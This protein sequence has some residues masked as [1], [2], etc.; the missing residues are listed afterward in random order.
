[1][2]NQDLTVVENVDGTALQPYRNRNE[3]RELAERLLSLHPAAAD[4]GQAGMFAVAQLALMIGASPLPGTN[5]IHVWAKEKGGQKVIQFQLGINYYRRKAQE[6]GGVLWAVQPRQMNDPERKDYGIPAGQLAAIC[7]GIRASEMEKWLRF[8]IPANQIWDMASAAGV[9][10]SGINEA[11]H[12]R[13][14]IWT[15]LKRAEVDVYRALFPTM[16]YQ[17][18][19]AQVKTDIEVVDNPDPGPSWDELAEFEQ[20]AAVDQETGE[21]IEG[22]IEPTEVEEPT[23]DPSDNG[24]DRLDEINGELGLFNSSQSTTEPEPNGLPKHPPKFID[25]CVDTIPRYDNV[26]AVK[27]ALKLLG[28]SGVKQD[29]DERERQYLALQLYANARDA[30]QGADDA[31][32]YVDQAM[33]EAADQEAA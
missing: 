18:A 21:I 23:P 16:M 30:G 7:R 1:M 2:G 29:D 14:A 11:K 12:G 4:V 19:E 28:Y 5:E 6:Q 22:E 33:N 9:G 24:Q 26:H 32:A 17:V 3:V 13:P 8:D 20:E 27:G 10:V 15:A 31:L 25:Y